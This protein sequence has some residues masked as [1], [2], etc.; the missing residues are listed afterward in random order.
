M[1]RRQADV[2]RGTSAWMGCGTKAT[3]QGRAWAMQGEQGADTWQ[4]ATRVHVD[5]CGCPC[6]AP[7]GRWGVDR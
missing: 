4:E 3:W 2:A 7:R 5:P 6:G 1:A